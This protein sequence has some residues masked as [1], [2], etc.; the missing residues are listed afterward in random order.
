[1][2]LFRRG[3][4]AWSRA[5]TARLWLTWKTA[6]VNL[7]RVRFAVLP[8]AIAA[9]VG[10]LGARRAPQIYDRLRKPAFAPPASVFGPVWSILYVAIAAAGWRVYGHASSKTRALHLTQLALNG[11]WPYTFFELRDKRASL[12]II[13][14]LDISLG[15]EVARLRDEDRRAA[16]LLVPYLA[17]S[18]FATALNAAV[19][20]PPH[21]N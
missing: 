16:A 5:W 21:N 15:L 10:G 19:S 13:V 12:A 6:F 2:P 1:M 9:A 3:S 8:V 11:A 17:W 18:G 20:E 7:R 4:G 14:L